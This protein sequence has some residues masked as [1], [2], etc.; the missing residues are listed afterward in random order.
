MPVSLPTPDHLNGSP[1]DEPL[2]NRG[3]RRLVLALMKPS[4]DGYNV[5]ISSRT[6]CRR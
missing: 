6:T 1:K 5:V 2:A 3:G 4:I